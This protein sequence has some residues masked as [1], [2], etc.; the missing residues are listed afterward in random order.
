MTSNIAPQTPSAPHI[1]PTEGIGVLPLFTALLI[2]GVQLSHLFAGSWIWLFLAVSLFGV[3]F[4]LSHGIEEASPCGWLLL[5]LAAVA[6]GAFSGGIRASPQPD[7]AALSGFHNVNGVISGTFTGEC[8]WKRDGSLLLPVD[9]I[10]FDAASQSIVWPG[11]LLLDV[12]KCSITPEPGQRYTATG[13][14]RIIKNRQSRFETGELSPASR[15]GSLG[16]L[17][18][19]IQRWVRDGT[20]GL[21]SVRHQ[22]MMVGF[23]I[24]DTSL[25]SFSDRRLFKETGVTHLLAVSGQHIMVLAILLMAILSWCGVPPLSRGILTITFLILFGF[26][27][28]GQPSVWR[29]VVMY[30]AGVIIWNLE[31]APSPLQPLAMAALFLILLDPAAIHDIGFQLSFMAVLG[32]LLG[33][34]PLER[35]LCRLGIPLLLARYLAVSFAANIATLPL[36]AYHFHFISLSAFIVNP[37]IVWTFELI[38]PMGILLAI[39]GHLWFAGGVLVAAGLSLLLDA[40]LAVIE[41][42][43]RLPFSQVSITFFPG[44]A[45]ACIYA[46]QLWWASK[47]SSSSQI[48]PV[49]AMEPQLNIEMSPVGETLSEGSRQPPSNI[50]LSGNTLVD[51]RRRLTNPLSDESTIAKI[52]QLLA[53]IPK[54][55]LKSRGN[56]EM[57]TF[58]LQKLSV[59]SQTLYHRLDDLTFDAMEK[60]P[61]RLIQAQVLLLGLFG[62]EILTRMPQLMNPPVRPEEIFTN[63]RARN[64]PLNAAILAECFF[65]SKFFHRIPEGNIAEYISH[66]R[67]L[68]TEGRLFLAQIIS[69]EIK[70]PEASVAEHFEQRRSVIAWIKNWLEKNI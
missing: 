68:H 9:E 21:L 51:L 3:F 37:L 64:R 25:L 17:I 70:N 61:E 65:S 34:E 19:G 44:I 12:S 26:V 22:S 36:V 41:M 62:G 57:T 53:S 58:P 20:C 31:A 33:R 59:D 16:P 60:E 30:A 55:S 54:R 39:F 52:D 1:S 40:V 47:V 32:I 27:A 5:G 23:I 28:A 4:E 67:T 14:M 43:G 10:T 49:P 24:G 56:L 45:V 42:G 50:T 69:S 13:T 35:P 15:Q 38:L 63:L 11:R 48:R 66:A 2:V 6:A 7:F 29:A 18:G 46:C 8:R